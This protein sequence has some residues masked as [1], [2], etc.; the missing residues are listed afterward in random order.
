[1]SRKFANNVSTLVLFETHQINVNFNLWFLTLI[2][3][4]TCNPGWHFYF[5]GQN[6]IFLFYF[7]SSC[8]LSSLFFPPAFHIISVLLLTISEI[9]SIHQLQR[10]SKLPII[11][12]QKCAQAKEGERVWLLDTQTKFKTAS[13]T[14]MI[15]TSE[16]STLMISTWVTRILTRRISTSATQARVILAC[17]ILI[18][19]TSMIFILMKST[20]ISSALMSIISMSKILMSR[21]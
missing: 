2:L 3:L 17:I 15:S 8:C 16:S 9:I 10:A 6:M 14:L 11:F 13:R 7:L 4:E 12:S 18:S 1:M 21:I 5:F 19:S 20:S